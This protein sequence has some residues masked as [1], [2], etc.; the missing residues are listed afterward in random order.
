MA[1]IIYR[2]NKK[3]GKRMKK[4][5]KYT[6]IVLILIYV[7]HIFITQQSTLNSYATESKEYESQIE[8]AKA[9]QTELNETIQDLNSTEYIEEQAREKLDMYLPNE[10]VYIDITK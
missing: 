6:F 1:N 4:F 9:T 5:L 7:V 2:L 8:S 3:I 10:R